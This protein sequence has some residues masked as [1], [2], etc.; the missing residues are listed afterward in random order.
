MHACLKSAFFCEEFAVPPRDAPEGGHHL[1]QVSPVRITIRNEGKLGYDCSGL[2]W[3]AYR[4]HGITI[5]RDADAQ[6]LAGRPIS[7]EDAQ[8]GDLIF[9]GTSFVHHVTMYLGKGMM[10]EAPNSASEVRISPVRTDDFA[11]VRTFL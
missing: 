7:L 1:R 2:T 10:I 4:A 6:A 5:P 11:G 9:Y 8:A 3:V